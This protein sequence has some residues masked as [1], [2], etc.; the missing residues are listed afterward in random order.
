MLRR[1]KFLFEFLLALS[2]VLNAILMA[3]YKT[4][5]VP[6]PKKSSVEETT[7]T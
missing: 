7:E 3:S 5:K 1:S 6:P 2:G 4:P